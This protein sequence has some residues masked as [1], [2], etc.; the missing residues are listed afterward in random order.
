MNEII[1][2]SL[3]FQQIIL[4][5]FA[6]GLGAFLRDVLEDGQIKLPTKV[7]GYLKF[8]FLSSVMVGAIVGF[9]IDGNFFTAFMGGYLGLS[10]NDAI[11]RKTK[12]EKPFLKIEKV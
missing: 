11:I 4:F 5:L 10:I 12:G 7:N 3:S 9:I 2:T 6:G 8:G 1:N